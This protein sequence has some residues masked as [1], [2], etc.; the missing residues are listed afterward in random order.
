MSVR[1]AWRSEHQTETEGYGTGRGEK[2]SCAFYI[3]LCNLY[4]SIAHIVQ[5]FL[6]FQDKRMNCND[7]QRGCAFVFLWGGEKKNCISIVYVEDEAVPNNISHF[8]CMLFIVGFWIFSWKNQFTKNHEVHEVGERK[9]SSHTLT[10]HI[11]LREK[12]SHMGAW[13]NT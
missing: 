7:L 8:K 1:G 12:L 6:L 13:Q 10:L 11:E 9:S 5:Q 3:T 2:H 4:Y